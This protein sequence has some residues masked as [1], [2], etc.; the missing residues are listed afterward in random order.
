MGEARLDERPFEEAT[1]RVRLA[2]LGREA[3]PALPFEVAEAMQTPLPNAVRRGHDD[4]ELLDPER[5]GL[6]AGIGV[7]K[8]PET[9]VGVATSHQA[10]HLSTG[11][12]HQ[13][14]RGCGMSTL[15]CS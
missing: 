7:R 14:D 8:V 3:E 15:E 6:E 4:D 13:L 2:A 1:E 12:S 9:E 10:A 5:L 11:R